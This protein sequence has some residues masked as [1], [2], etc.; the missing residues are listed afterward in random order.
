MTDDFGHGTHVAGIIAGGARKDI[1]VQLL[2]RTDT[3][4]AR[5][6]LK[7]GPLE[8]TGTMPAAHFAPKAKSVIYLFMAGAPSQV[9]LFDE[10]PKLRQYDG[11]AIPEEFVKGE[12]FAFIKGTPKLLGS[13]YAFK[14][15]GQSGGRDLRPAAAHP[16][17]SRTT[18]RSCARCTPRSST[19]PPPRSS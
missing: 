9:D 8:P 5:G 12:R 16:G 3:V 11:Q 6:E 17:R 4:D 19:T 10:K 18:S 13:P 15:C 7:R 2:E 1:R 14:K